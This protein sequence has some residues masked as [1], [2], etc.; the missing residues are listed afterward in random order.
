MMTGTNDPLPSPRQTRSENV[1]REASRTL[2]FW[3]T[4]ELYKVIHMIVS[5]EREQR[6]L[7]TVVS[8]QEKSRRNRTRLPRGFSIATDILSIRPD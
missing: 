6:M 7:R 2:S 3:C 8:Q 5:D 1:D 4:M